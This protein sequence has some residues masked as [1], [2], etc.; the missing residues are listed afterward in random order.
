MNSLMMETIVHPHGTT[1]DRLIAEFSNQDYISYLYITHGVQ[2][3][4]VTHTKEN[5]D[6]PIVE[7]EESQSISVYSAEISA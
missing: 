7:H 5:N 6:N 1:V 2:S 3:G 4:F